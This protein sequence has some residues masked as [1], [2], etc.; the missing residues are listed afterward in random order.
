MRKKRQTQYCFRSPLEKPNG[1]ERVLALSIILEQ[2]EKAEQFKELVEAFVDEVEDEIL[3]SLR[4]NKLSLE[5]LKEMK[6]YYQ[7]VEKFRS[8]TKELI[9]RGKL[10]AN[11]LSKLQERKE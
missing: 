1:K 5:D 2:G 3:N 8:F 7:A 4:T 10:K 11:S 9:Q 6:N